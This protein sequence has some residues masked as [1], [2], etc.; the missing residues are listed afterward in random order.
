MAQ[1]RICLICLM[2]A[3]LGSCTDDAGFVDSTIVI[4]GVELFR[5]HHRDGIDYG[6]QRLSDDR[7]SGT[8][9]IP[10]PSDLTGVLIWLSIDQDESVVYGEVQ[11]AFGRDATYFFIID[12]VKYYRY[13]SEELMLN[14]LQDRRLYAIDFVSPGAWLRGRRPR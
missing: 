6:L 14:D 7:R 1:W 13:P 11:G 12:D 9:M 5:V 10:D 3:V 4:D 8:T 2:V